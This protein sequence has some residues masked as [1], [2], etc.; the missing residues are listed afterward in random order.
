[1]TTSAETS[2]SASETLDLDSRWGGGF[3][4]PA[5]VSTQFRQGRGF[6][7][8]AAGEE[9]TCQCGRRKRPRFDPWVG[10]IPWRRKWQPTPVFTSIYAW[11]I[12]WTER[13]VGCSL[14][15]HKEL[16]TTEWLSTHTCNLYSFLCNSQKLDTTKMFLTGKW[17]N[18]QQYMHTMEYCSTV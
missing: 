10:K 5:Q 2:T 15:G 12:P 1:M 8:G 16:D 9:P 17:L 13:L 7:G 14:W 18:K 11:R 3:F 4:L 6:P